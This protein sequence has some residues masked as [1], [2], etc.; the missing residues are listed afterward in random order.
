MEF[1]TEFEKIFDSVYPKQINL[2]S[3]E[4]KD[5]LNPF[6]WYKNDLKKPIRKQLYNIAVEFI[7]NIEMDKVVIADIVLVG[8]IAGFN[9]SKFSDIDLHI[10]LDFDKLSKEYGDKETLK[11]LFDHER[12]AFNRKHNNLYIY[13]YP[14]EL[15]VQDINEKNESNGIYSILYSKWIKIPDGGNALTHK[16]L[17]K[18]KAAQFINVID[19]YAGY[20]NRNLSKNQYIILLDRLNKIH[21]EIVQG[22]RTSLATEGE[23]APDNI[24]FKVLRRSGHL[25]ILNDARVLVYDKMNSLKTKHTPKK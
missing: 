5:I 25:G 18:K 10:I 16:E 6:I 12:L 24:V 13:G 8:S 4:T 15:Y 14:V 11:K 7:E 17:I 23:Y 9:W 1:L 21:E 20:A 2:K 22:R 19:R 3:F